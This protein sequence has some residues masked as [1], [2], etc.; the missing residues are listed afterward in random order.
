MDIND[1]Y[2]FEDFKKEV[3]KIGLD[4]SLNSLSFYKIEECNTRL[5]NLLNLDFCTLLSRFIVRRFQERESWY[6]S[7]DLYMLLW[8]K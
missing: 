1:I 8:L 2:D 4:L 7:S 5:N 3:N 6:D